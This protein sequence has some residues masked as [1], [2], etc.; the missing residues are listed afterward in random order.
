[1]VA[2]MLP[3]LKFPEKVQLPFYRLSDTY[4]GC[5]Q[6]SKA[7]PAVV[8]SYRS[9]GNMNGGQKGRRITGGYRMPR[10]HFLGSK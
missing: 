3:L 6:K 1:M 9:T 10:G 7:L 5:S 8:A 4:M 2:L